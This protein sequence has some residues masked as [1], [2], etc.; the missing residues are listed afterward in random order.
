[1]YWVMKTFADLFAKWDTI[2]AFGADIGVSD[3]HARA[4][5]RRGSVPPE[6]WPQLVRAAKSKGVREVDIEA[7]AEMRAARRQNRASSAGVAA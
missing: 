5:K 1:M 4:M 7:L 6:Y 2:A 3:M